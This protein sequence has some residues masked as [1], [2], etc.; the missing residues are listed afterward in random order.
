MLLNILLLTVK[1]T[2]YQSGYLHLIMYLYIGYN[3]VL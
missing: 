3:I 1:I 2:I